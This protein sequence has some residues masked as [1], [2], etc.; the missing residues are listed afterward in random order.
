MRSAPNHCNT[1][2]TISLCPWAAAL[3]MDRALNRGAESPSSKSSAS[4]LRG[5]RTWQQV[6]PGGGLRRSMGRLV[7]KGC[8][9]VKAQTPYLARQQ[10]LMAQDVVLW[11]DTARHR[12]FASTTAP[13]GVCSMPL[14]G[15]ERTLLA[16]RNV[17][18]ILQLDG[19]LR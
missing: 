14:E 19:T 8:A 11:R 5:R 12:E 1:H 6:F 13:L 16:Q 4:S 7:C 18:P 3:G 15:S 9:L 17:R 10:R 2:K